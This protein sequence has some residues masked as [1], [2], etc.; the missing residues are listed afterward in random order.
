DG[1]VGRRIAPAG[2]EKKRAEDEDSTHEVLL[3][4]R[5]VYAKKEAAGRTRQPQDRNGSS[6]SPDYVLVVV[7][8]VVV[9]FMS[10]ALTSLTTIVLSVVM[11]FMSTA[12]MSFSTP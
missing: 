3:T 1:V 9:A 2:S 10:T 5:A 8:S 11:A 6:R 4:S 12:L 7:L